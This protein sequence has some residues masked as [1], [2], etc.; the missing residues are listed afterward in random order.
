MTVPLQAF[1]LSLS[2]S[3]VSSL[4]LPSR[5]SSFWFF[6]LLYSSQYIPRTCRIKILKAMLAFSPQTHSFF[7][8][9]SIPSPKWK[10]PC[11]FEIPSQTYSAAPPPLTSWMQPGHHGGAPESSPGRPMAFM[12]LYILFP[13]LDRALNLQISTVFVKLSLLFLRIFS[14]SSVL[15]KHFVHTSNLQYLPHWYH[16]N[17]V[18]ACPSSFLCLSSTFLKERDWLIFSILPHVTPNKCQAHCRSSKMSV[19]FNWSICL[20]SFVYNPVQ[21]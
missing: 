4:A 14:S 10:S 11:H 18:R 1:L 15:P 7:A 17:S 8:L 5:S 9:R 21:R 13:S 12:P 16:G 20:V 6:F 2:Y 3:Q 19:L